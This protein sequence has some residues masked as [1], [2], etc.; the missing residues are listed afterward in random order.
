[1]AV[2]YKDDEKK[3]QEQQTPQ[4]DPYNGMRGI[5]ENTAA[6]IGKYNQGYQESDTVKNA[7]DQMNT[8]MAQKPQGFTSK[9]SPQLDAILQKI[10]N[11]EKF[12]YSINGDAFL[13]EYLDRYQRNGQKAM[14]DTIGN[15]AALTGGYGNSYAAQ[16]G[17]QAYQG[18][19]Q[20][21]YAQLPSFYDRAYQANRDE[22][23]DQKDLY[24]ILAER[25]G[26]DYDRYRDEYKDWEGERDY[27]TDRYDTESDR[28]YGRY[29]NERDYWA[30][31]GQQENADW[32]TGTNFDEQK[33]QYEQD[34]AEKVRQF[35]EQL[36]EQK[37][38]ADLDEAYR[39]DMFAYQ[40][41]QD[42]AAAAAAAAG[43]SSGS[44]S[45]RNPGTSGDVPNKG[46]IWEGYTG[47]TVS[48]T[49]SA[50]TGKVTNDLTKSRAASLVK[51]LKK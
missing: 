30:G 16:A 50:S 41:A 4:T 51:K 43:G 6:Q 1:M 31:L 45:S 5:S 33:R 20:D 23:G 15:A 12:K 8:I 10:Q 24:G 40:Q 38:Q 34:Y 3:L 39:R 47:K 21:A 7:R 32:W 27:F 13:Q 22:L 19:M 29:G 14:M 25:E 42:A 44:P 35:N 49:S 28:D 37:R 46:T 18:Y 2:T 36:A 48:A 11:P 26:T 17:Q 9:Y